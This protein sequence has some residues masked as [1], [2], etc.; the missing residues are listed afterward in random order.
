MKKICLNF[1]SLSLVANVVVICLSIA[2]GFSVVAQEHNSGSMSF[3][4]DNDGLLGSDRGYTNGIFFKFN[5]SSVVNIEQLSPLPIRNIARWLPLYQQTNKGWG[6]TFGQQIWTPSD[7]ATE[8]EQSNDRPYTG[9]LFVKASI[10]ESSDN[11]ANKYSLML[12]GVGP[13]ALGEKSQK[14]VHSLIGSKTP[15]GWHRQIDSQAVFNLSYETQRL[16]T[17][18]QTWHGQDYDTA[19]TGRVNLGNFQNEIALGSVIR[20]GSD[21]QGSFASVGFTP[22][23]YI[24]ASVLSTSNTGQFVY[25]ALEGRYRFNDITIDGA[26]PKHLFDVH[27]EHW[28][29]TISTGVVYYQASWGV[30]FSVVASTPDYKEDIRKHNATASIEVFWRV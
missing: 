10:F 19:L 22:G 26:R 24:D 2:M 17:R 11:I 12:G 18:A 28:Q 16:L 15:M 29:S 25:V 23:N 4:V 3:S 20:W 6:V 9:L 1:H 8:L 21:L 30:A 27:T 7:I 14:A 5:S 13:N